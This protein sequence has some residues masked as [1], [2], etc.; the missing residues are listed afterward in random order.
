MSYN[1]LIIGGGI[2]ALS[3]ARSLNEVGCIVTSFVDQK[4]YITKCK[5]IDHEISSPIID[6]GEYY[7]QFLYDY[8][9]KYPQKVIIPMRDNHADFLSR[10]KEEIERLFEAKCAIPGYDVFKL[11]NDKWELLQVCAKFG[12]PHPRTMVLSGDSLKAVAEYIG[13]PALIKPNIS[14]G[15]KGITLVNTIEE[16]SLK[17]PSIYKLYGNCTL[18]EYI[19]NAGPYYNVML[20]RD[21]GGKIV[22]YTI[23]EILR[24]YP[25]KGGS[26]CFCKAIENDELIKLCSRTLEILNWIGFA[27][28]DILRN[29][30]G[31]F[32]IIEINPRIPSSIRAAAISGVNFPSLIVYDL[33]NNPLQQYNYQKGSYLRYLGLDIMWFLSSSKR[34]RAKPS[35]FRFIG[36]DI[37]Y[38]DFTWDDPLPFF[39]GMIGNIKKQFSPE[40]RKS[41]AVL[42]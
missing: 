18:Q 14:I 13:F 5:F 38:Q 8:L 17:Y 12:L 19:D 29:R 41:K 30:D 16:I 27:D 23:I 1:I 10:N 7:K 4:D 6:N 35:W 26:S 11:A 25:V 15:A 31:D 24:Y 40:F 34:F 33:I 32:K 42:R 36:K 28:F 22:N 39:L 9:S 21:R 20:Y 3:V 2:Q 37:F